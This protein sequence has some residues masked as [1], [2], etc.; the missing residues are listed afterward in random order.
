VTG[1][2]LQVETSPGDG[3][4]VYLRAPVTAAASEEE[5]R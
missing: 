5:M 2:T 4:A 1:A 3:T